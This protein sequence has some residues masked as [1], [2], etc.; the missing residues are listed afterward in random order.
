M[1]RLYDPLDAV[2]L[3]G[4]L[5]EV[6]RPCNDY[7]RFLETGANGLRFVA[8]NLY[9]IIRSMDRSVGPDAGQPISIDYGNLVERPAGMTEDQMVI[10]GTV[11]W[12]SR[13][14]YII[15]GRERVRLTHHADAHDVAA[16]WNCLEVMLKAETARISSLLSRTG[17]PLSTYTAL[18]HPD[19][20][21]WETEVEPLTTVH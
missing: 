2:G 14:A 9:G 16:E 4:W 18:M 1:A 15:D 5:S 20:R 11:G 6:N 8:L 17:E 19:G 10:G 13:G 7:T 21:R 3:N 12:S